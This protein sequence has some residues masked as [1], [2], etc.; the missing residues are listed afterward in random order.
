MCIM[1]IYHAMHYSRMQLHFPCIRKLVSEV[2]FL[3]F[4][5]PL[6]FYAFSGIPAKVNLLGEA[7]KFF[8]SGCSLHVYFTRYCS[9]FQLPWKYTCQRGK[10][11]KFSRWCSEV[12][13]VTCINLYQNHC[14]L[15]DVD[16]AVQLIS[17]NNVLCSLICGSSVFYLF[18]FWSSDGLNCLLKMM[19][20]TGLPF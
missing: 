13:Y 12:D 4:D 19:G 9:T 20:N 15:L 2:I 8:R 7:T 1:C 5:F 14:F 3:G 16:L 6:L 10:K 18:N 17:L 11:F